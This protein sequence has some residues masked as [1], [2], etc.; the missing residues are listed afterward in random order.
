MSET[1]LVVQVREGTGKSVARKLRAS[2]RAPAV[3]Y[4]Q[5]KDSVPIAL[6][7]RQLEK[8]LRQGGLNTLLDV[9]VEG[10][11][12]LSGTVALVKE[13]QRDAVRGGLLHADLFRVDLTQKVEVEVPVHLTGKSAGVELGGVLDHMLREITLSCLPRRIPDSIEADVSA[14]EVGDVLHVRDLA[15]PADVELIT[16]GELAVAHV[17]TPTVAEDETP[18]DEAVSAE[19]PVVGA[20]DGADA[21][22]GDSG[23]SS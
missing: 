5:G 2:G 13:L 14:L 7:P 12:D 1:Q 23:S 3:I 6:D 19:V 18:A 11:E 22:E 9:I 20:E 15:L 8:I 17:V 16:D 10:R 4:G 21:S